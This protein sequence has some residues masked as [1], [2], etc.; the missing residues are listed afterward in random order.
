MELS[1]RKRLEIQSKLP[2]ISEIRKRLLL[3]VDGIAAKSGPQKKTEVAIVC[4]NDA[5]T[6]GG[7]VIYALSQAYTNLLWYREEH[8]KAPLEREACIYAKFYIDDAALRLYAATEHL[9]NFIIAFIDI[10]ASK[11]DPYRKKHRSLASVTGNYMKKEMST[12]P[13][14]HKVKQLIKDKHWEE[15]IRYRNVWVH[16]Q[17]PLIEGIGI[18][19][20]RNVRWRQVEDG[21]YLLSFGTGDEPDYTIDYLIE[22]VSSASHTLVN[23]LSDFAEILVAYLRNMGIE[24]DSKTGK[25]RF[26]LFD[27]P[28]C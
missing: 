1:K 25:I 8:P 20:K 6:V 4:L 3:P 15:T 23:V 11:L 5:V 2:Q 10:E 22:M 12:H 26:K 27:Y 28:E 17:P 13:I 14:T 21:S 16:E 19:Y 24:L 18:V 7:E 9:V